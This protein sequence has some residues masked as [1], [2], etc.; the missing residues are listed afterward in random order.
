MFSAAWFTD[1]EYLVSVLFVVV[2]V[3]WKLKG[4]S[5]FGTVSEGISKKKDIAERM[6][7][8]TFSCH[9]E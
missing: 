3:L 8:I 7:K 6:F 9:Q 5:Y 4:T 1:G 2:I